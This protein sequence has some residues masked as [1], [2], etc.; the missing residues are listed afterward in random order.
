[1]PFERSTPI[2]EP[3]PGR[4]AMDDDEF[5]GILGGDFGI[6]VCEPFGAA[7]KKTAWYYMTKGDTIGNIF[8]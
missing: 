5:F 8:S 6:G 7:F 2:T 3:F 4:D 1:M